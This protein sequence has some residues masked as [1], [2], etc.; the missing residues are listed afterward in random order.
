MTKRYDQ[1]SGELIYQF[2]N[3]SVYR[4][5]N[6]VRTP[7]STIIL[8]LILILLFIPSFISAQISISS[9]GSKPDPSA[10][11]D[12]KSSSKGLLIPRVSDTSDVT[13]KSDGLL[14]YK[15]TGGKGFYYF[16]SEKGWIALQPKVT[17]NA[18]NNICNSDSKGNTRYNTTDNRLEVCTGTEWEVIGSQI[19]TLVV[20]GELKLG[21]TDK[22]CDA[23]T[24]G[25]L[26]YNSGKMEI[27]SAGSWSEV[28]TGSGGSTTLAGLTDS[29]INSPADNSL[30]R[31]NSTSGKWE[32][33]EI[34]NAIGTTS[35]ISGW[36]DAIYCK[37]ATR[38]DL[39]YY[40]L[41]E[42]NDVYYIPPYSNP[43]SSEAY[44]IIFNKNTKEYDRNTG[45]TSLANYDCIANTK[46]ISQLYADGQ[47]FNLLGGIDNT[48]I[49][50][51]QSFAGLPDKVPTGW[52]ICDGRE[53]NRS[54]YSTLYDII[55]NSWGE[56]DG[57]TTFNIPDLR[58]QF[59]RGVDTGATKDPDVASRT[60]IKTGGNTGDNVGSIQD[61]QYKSH[62]H[63]PNK[64][65]SILEG[66]GNGGLE[67]FNFSGG[68][69]SSQSSTASSGGSETRPK[70]AYVYFIIKAFHT[71]SGGATTPQTGQAS[72]VASTDD[73]TSSN[74]GAIRYN[75]TI[76]NMQFCDGNEWNFFSNKSV[77]KLYTDT[78]YWS[79][80][81]H[82]TSCKEYLEKSATSPVDGVYT[83]D[84][85]GEAGTIT[86]FKV[87]CD[88][89]TDGGGWTVVKQYGNGDNY[90][91]TLFM[92]KKNSMGIS[93]SFQGNINDNTY[94]IKYYNQFLD[95]SSEVMISWK[96][97]ETNYVEYDVGYVIWGYSL[98]SFN[99]ALESETNCGNAGLWTYNN[100]GCDLNNSEEGITKKSADFS[101]GYYAFMDLQAAGKDYGGYNGYSV[102]TTNNDGGIYADAYDDGIIRISFR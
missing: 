67:S 13:V 12:V 68:P 70:N 39:L 1:F 15:N 59:L 53:L 17:F 38:N 14:V 65:S 75:S 45:M 27:C 29:D 37:S 90:S 50:T 25:S 6:K 99:P 54:D 102:W 31:Y 78:Y 56:G 36:P 63:S 5:N 73:C 48:P 71:N 18:A 41:T 84:P 95:G 82:A 43:G 46:S 22:V 23:S 57:S 81:K 101:V 83:I 98:R 35:M 19:D 66:G 74:E 24:E 9:D 61:D 8:I 91:N 7:N 2:D 85:D 80:G 62:S 32:N 4:N 52:L 92:A 97:T 10:M 16:D 34:N 26:R 20:E 3:K 89:T 47:A 94:A 96:F 51:V 40:T 21:N 72:L 100:T 44:F 69:N 42:N 93:D 64:G 79:D 58:G 77:L 88:M 30:L 76:K 55:S 60:A 28:G 33:S 86:P 11:L 49:G 87:H